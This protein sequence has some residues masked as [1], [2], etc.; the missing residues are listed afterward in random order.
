[1]ATLRN[2]VVNFAMEVE[3]NPYL[4][5]NYAPI[6]TEISSENLQVI[7]EIPK[8]LNGMYVRNG[9]NPRYAPKGRYHWFDGD[10]MLH[11]VTI[12]DGKVSYRNRYIHTDG[13]E[14]E[15]HAGG[16]LWTGIMEPPFNN[17]R[18]NVHMPVKDTANTTIDYH[19]GKLIA[20]WYLAGE[21]YSI[22]PH[23]LETIGKEDFGGSLRSNMSAHCKVDEHNNEL[24]F[25]DYSPRPP[26]MMYGVV[27]A[28]GQLQHCVPIDLPGPRLPHDMAITQNY[29]ILLDLPLVSDPAAMKAGRHKIVF[30]RDWPSRFGVIPRY[31]ESDEIRWF[32]GSPC[33][34]YHT[35]NAWEEVRADG[36][37]EIVMDACRVNRPAPPITAVTRLEKMLGYLRLDARIYRYRF[38]L[39][40]GETKEEELD[41]VN[42]EFPSINSSLLGQ[43]SRY[44]YNVSI[45]SDT[46]LL[47]DGLIKYDTERGTSEKY[48]FGKGR[49]GSEAPFA[50]RTNAVDEDDGYLLSFIYDER[51]SRSELIILDAQ[52]ITDEPLARVIIPQRVPYGFHACWVP[53]EQLGE[54][55]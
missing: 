18:Q 11:A 3:T 10:G 32:E 51:E 22:D 49:Y 27:G 23:T 37:I 45:T 17:P 30:R 53:G 36:A 2:D 40:T 52:H 26:Y 7:G 5:G 35:I 38:N 25:F 12:R 31:G 1:M 13:F 44:A 14:R 43:K 15:A 33:Y 55:N 48:S 20:N 47:F 39:Q 50:P 29:S 8:D 28:N 46:T 19:N 16:L 42:T 34:M 21:P 54:G 9:P 41:D 4:M 24:L 6:D